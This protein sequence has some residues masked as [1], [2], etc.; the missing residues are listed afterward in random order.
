ME[1]GTVTCIVLFIQGCCNSWASTGS[2][3]TRNTGSFWAHV[4]V[5]TETLLV[6]KQ[7]CTVAARNL[8]FFYK[9]RKI[10]N[11]IEELDSAVKR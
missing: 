7:S 11:K 4:L 8:S 10:Y 2:T 6:F 9:L 5:S 1:A 3:C